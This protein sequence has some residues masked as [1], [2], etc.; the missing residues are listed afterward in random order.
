MYVAN[1]LNILR[2][3][4]LDRAISAVSVAVAQWRNELIGSP[5]LV[6]SVPDRRARSLQPRRSS[7]SCSS[8][9]TAGERSVFSSFPKIFLQF[10]HL[11]GA[12]DAGEDHE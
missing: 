2:S 7:T 3:D 6:G 10:L 4:V 8:R 12:P 11:S 1:Q 9:R 5:E